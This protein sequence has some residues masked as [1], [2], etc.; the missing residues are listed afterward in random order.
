[1]NTIICPTVLAQDPHDYRTQMD[2]VASFAPRVQ[3]DLADG[4][5]TGNKTVGVGQVWWPDG[6]KADLHMMY[7]N[8]A[9]QLNSLLKIKPHMV[10][11]HAEAEGDFAQIAEPLRMAGIKLG[12]ALLQKTGVENIQPVLDQLD[13]VM[14]FAG[15]LGH[16]GGS[17]DLSMLS[18]VDKLKQLNSELEIGW[19]GGVTDLNVTE[20]ARGGVDVLNVGGY[21]QHAVDPATAYATLKALVQK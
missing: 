21:I 3:I 14:I 9:K 17:A 1:V 16:F 5:F 20:L 19:D 10:I 8:P 15:T 2:R 6:V 4:R 11:V 18:K 7:Q 13:H 12:L